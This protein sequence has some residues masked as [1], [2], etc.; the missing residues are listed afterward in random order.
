[1]TSFHGVIHEAAGS[2]VR[3]GLHQRGK[4]DVADVGFGI[5]FPTVLAYDL[6]IFVLVLISYTIRVVVQKSAMAQES[7]L[8]CLAAALYTAQV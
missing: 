6:I 3:R 5:S 1:M 4:Q 7:R 8:S 2:V